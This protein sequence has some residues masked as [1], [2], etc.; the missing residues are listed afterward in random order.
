[1]KVFRCF[2]EAHMRS[3]QVG[4]LPSFSGGEKAF[5]AISGG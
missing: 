3:E 1:M 4:P 5:A 2:Y